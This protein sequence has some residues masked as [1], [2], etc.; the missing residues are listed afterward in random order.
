MC[1]HP[2]EESQSWPAKAGPT[3]HPGGPSAQLRV[4][5]DRLWPE[6]R[7]VLWA[8]EP[9]KLCQEAS[10]NLDPEGWGG[11]PEAEWRASQAELGDLGPVA[12]Q[13]LASRV[14]V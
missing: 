8:R 9:G 14:G 12:A 13:S 2:K 3:H 1:S 6:E 11:L 4:S 7:L 5:Q 10:L